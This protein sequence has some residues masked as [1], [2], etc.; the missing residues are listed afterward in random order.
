M[1]QGPLPKVLRGQPARAEGLGCEVNLGCGAVSNKGP[2]LVGDTVSGHVL[3]GA[4]H[5]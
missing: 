1:P 3:C 5:A 4:H 2:T